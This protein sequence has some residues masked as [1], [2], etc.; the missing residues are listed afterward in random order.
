MDLLDQYPWHRFH[1]MVVHPEFQ[2]RVWEA[3]QRKR[4]CDQAE[5]QCT[6]SDWNWARPR[7]R[8]ARSALTSKSTM[9]QDLLFFPSSSPCR[10]SR[11]L[12]FPRPQWPCPTPASSV[13][14]FTYCIQP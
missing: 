11:L 3:V 14:A 5:G 8:L 4:E 12:E 9:T 13:H 10:R 7:A 2:Q 6:P 1:P